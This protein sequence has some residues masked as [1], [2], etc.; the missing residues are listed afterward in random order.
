MD[1]Y[2]KPVMMALT[3]RMIPFCREAGIKTKL[4]MGSYNNIKITTRGFN[5]AQAIIEA[6]NL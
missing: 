2:R 1:S 6:E 3:V 5:F 4:V